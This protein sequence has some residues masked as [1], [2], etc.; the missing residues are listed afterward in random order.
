[1]FPIHISTYMYLGLKGTWQCGSEVS[2]EG[3]GGVEWEL[4]RHEGGICI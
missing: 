1:M 2:R 4:G 3:G